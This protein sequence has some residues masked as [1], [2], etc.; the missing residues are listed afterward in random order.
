MCVASS[1]IKDPAN[2]VSPRFYSAV[3]SVL[4]CIL[5][6]LLRRRFSYA[7]HERFTS[8]S[9]IVQE[10]C[11]FPRIWFEC[12]I[13]AAAILKRGAMAGCGLD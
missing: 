11:G 8:I 3:Q 2:Q 12:L 6:C 9:D 10:I 1:S 13:F 5:Q 7:Y 4:V